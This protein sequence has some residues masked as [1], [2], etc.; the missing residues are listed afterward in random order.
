MAT[1]A[2]LITRTYSVCVVARL[3]SDI[4]IT[5]VVAKIPML[6]NLA[7]LV[8]VLLA[9]EPYFSCGLGLCLN[10]GNGLTA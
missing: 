5:V 8:A 6:G 1:L 3:P 2:I 9:Y 10:L 4:Y 7:T